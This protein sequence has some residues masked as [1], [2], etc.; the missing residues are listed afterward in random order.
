MTQ[1]FWADSTLTQGLAADSDS[2]SAQRV[3]MLSQVWLKSDPEVSRLDSDPNKS[4]VDS[5]LTQSSENICK[6]HMYAYMHAQSRCMRTCMHR[7]HVCVHACRA[8][9]R[10]HACAEHMYV[11]I[12][13]HMYKYIG[14]EYMYVLHTYYNYY[15]HNI[16]IINID[17]HQDMQIQ[18]IYISSTIVIQR[19]DTQC[20]DKW[21]LSEHIAYA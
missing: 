6:A 3:E 21:Q 9:V 7:A 1:F 12:H 8:H 17:V 2:D 13:A 10:V 19:P 5:S 18:E 15:T 14:A 11:H 20:P 16:C 4:W